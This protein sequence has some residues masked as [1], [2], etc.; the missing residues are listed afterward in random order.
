MFLT[1]KGL[2]TPSIS[3]NAC[4]AATIATC[5][6][7]PCDAWEFGGGEMIDSQASQGTGRARL[8]LTRLIRSST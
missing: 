1:S 5:I 2:H 6:G 4:I 7:I 8:I 3:S